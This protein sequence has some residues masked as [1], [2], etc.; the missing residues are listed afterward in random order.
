MPPPPSQQQQQQPLSCDLPCSSGAR[1]AKHMGKRNCRT[2][3]PSPPAAPHH[4]HSPNPRHGQP[5][6]RCSICH[7]H[8]FAH[9]RQCCSVQHCCSARSSQAGCRRHRRCRRRCH[10]RPRQLGTRLRHTRR[11]PWG[12]HRHLASQ[13]Q[14]Q[15]QR[16]VG[17]RRVTA[18]VAATGGP[19]GWGPGPRGRQGTTGS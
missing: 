3:G 11:S 14:Q 10:P 13:H 6:S 16:A 18:P 15:Q 17:R 12:S 1:T 8:S 9:P 5:P 7:T 19:R 4:T 2:Y